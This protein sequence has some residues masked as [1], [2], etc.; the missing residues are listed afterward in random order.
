MP[1]ASLALSIFSSFTTLVSWTTLAGRSRKHQLFVQLNLQLL[2]ASAIVL[3]M[4][5]RTY[6]SQ[7]DEEVGI[8]AK[9]LIIDTT[10]VS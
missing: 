5:C 1:G 3:A 6:P 4:V 9:M 10:S 8:C 2:Y 7:V